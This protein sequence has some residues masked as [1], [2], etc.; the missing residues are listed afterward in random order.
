MIR[1]IAI[2][3]EPRAL[4]IIEKHADRIDFLDLEKTFT[5]PFKAITYLK[6]NS[7]DLLLLDINMPDINGMEL[8]KYLGKKSLIIFTTA[9]SEYAIE[10]YEYEAV[11]Y[12]LKPFAF[13]RFF[14]AVS[15]AKERMTPSSQGDFFFVNSGN[16]KRKLH[17][18]DIC[19]LESKGNYIA[20]VTSK[21]EVLVRAS[22]K[23]ALEQLPV[24]LFHQIHRSFV[25]SLQWIDRIEDNHVHV[26]EKSISIGATWRE[27]FLKR[28]G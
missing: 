15:K 4:E 14:Q 8:L 23:D 12:L 17:F 13:A 6:E 3:D 24:G 2:D 11:D 25:V 9:H 26:G 20:Y 19:Y 1:C 5:E 27:A 21:E 10:S 7:V 28:I 18:D 22:I 16:Q